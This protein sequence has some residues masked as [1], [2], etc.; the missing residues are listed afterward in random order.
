MTISVIGRLSAIVTKFML[1]NFKV[2]TIELKE[3]VTSA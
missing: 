2:C 1:Y 3:L